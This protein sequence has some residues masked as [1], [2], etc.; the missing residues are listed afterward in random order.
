MESLPLQMS[1]IIE[2]RRVQKKKS[3]FSMLG[4]K[5]KGTRQAMCFYF[6]KESENMQQVFN[7]S[8]YDIYIY[9]YTFYV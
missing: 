3:P 4:G 8:L 9:I 7:T 6:P 2:L 5:Q 1:A